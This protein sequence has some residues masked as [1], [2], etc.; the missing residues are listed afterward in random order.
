LGKD[1]NILP[2]KSYS[3]SFFV[4]F[5]VFCFPLLFPFPFPFLLCLLQLEGMLLLSFLVREGQNIKMDCPNSR[6]Y[7]QSAEFEVFSGRFFQFKGLKLG[8][9]AIFL[10]LCSRKLK[11]LYTKTKHILK[12]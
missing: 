2:R 11:C 9:L 7:R 12:V 1:T 6:L 8:F 5:F 3:S 10:Y 4:H